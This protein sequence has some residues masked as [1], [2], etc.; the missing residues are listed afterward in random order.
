MTAGPVHHRLEGR[1]VVELIFEELD[2]EID[3]RSRQLLRAHVGDC[4]ECRSLQGSYRRLQDRMAGPIHD[5]AEIARARTDSLRRI[6]AEARTARRSFVGWLAVPGAVLL[7]FAVAAAA[8]FVRTSVAT[9]AYPDREVVV[10]RSFSVPGGQATLVI[11][12][13]ARYALPREAT[14]VISRADVRF[15]ER[16]QAGFAETRIREPG[17]S[18]GIIA[19]APDLRG[20]SRFAVEGRF[21]SVERGVTKILHVWLYLEPGGFESDMVTIEL[22]YAAGGGTRAVLR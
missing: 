11:E 1:D 21:P 12:Q 10:E 20:S 5:R 15:G 16:Q 13:G 6:S 8:M 22:S 4:D 2:G 17:E 7:V 9:P 19:R 3:A 18:Y 14:G